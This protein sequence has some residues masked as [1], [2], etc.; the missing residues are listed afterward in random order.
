VKITK[1]DKN[2]TPEDPEFAEFRE[3]HSHN[4]RDKIWDNDGI[5]GSVQKPIINATDANEENLEE[6]ISL[7][8]DLSDLEVYFFFT[9][10]IT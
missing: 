9:Y 2:K 4:Q 3:I 1:Q 7:K 5:D 8:K 10:L 6:K